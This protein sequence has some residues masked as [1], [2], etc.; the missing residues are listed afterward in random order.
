MILPDAADVRRVDPI[1]HSVRQTLS[2]SQ[3]S[4]LGQPVY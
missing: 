4:S 3:A 2:P 1:L